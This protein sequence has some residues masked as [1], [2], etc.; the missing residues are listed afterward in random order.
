ML[1]PLKGGLNKPKINDLVLD[2]NPLVNKD[3]ELG[4]KTMEIDGNIETNAMSTRSKTKT[5]G[6][7][8]IMKKETPS[9]RKEKENKVSEGLKRTHQKK[10]LNES[11]PNNETQSPAE[12]SNELYNDTE[13]EMDIDYEPDDNESEEIPYLP[14]STFKSEIQDLKKEDPIIEDF[15]L[16][17]YLEPEL[18]SITQKL[19]HA[20]PVIESLSKPTIDENTTKGLA[21]KEVEKNLVKSTTI[22]ENM[23]PT[24]AIT[25]APK[26]VIRRKRVSPFHLNAI[27]KEQLFKGILENTELKFPFATGLGLIPELRAYVHNA[28]R[29][30]LIPVNE[31][32]D[33]E[34]VLN[35]I[36]QIMPNEIDGGDD[37][38]DE[39][40]LVEALATEVETIDD[41]VSKPVII[42]DALILGKKVKIKYDS[43]S[44][45]SFVS[46]A[47]VDQLNLQIQN[48]SAVVG[49]INPGSKVVKGLVE[50]TITIKGIELP[51]TMLIHENLP[52]DTI[53]VGRNFQ[54]ENCF[55][56]G[57]VDSD[58]NQELV[59]KHNNRLLKFKLLNEN[60]LSWKLEEDPLRIEKV[61]EELEKVFDNSILTNYQRSYFKNAI[62]GI[63]EVF[64]MPGDKPGK[65]DSNKFELPNIKLQENVTPWKAK[66]IP[67]GKYRND[68]IKILREM[69]DNG[70]LKYLNLNYRNPWFMVMKSNKSLRLLVDYRMLN[71]NILLQAA[72]PLNAM[73]M[74]NRMSGKY[75]CTF[76]DISNAYFQVGIAEDGQELTAIMTPIGLLQFAVLPQGYVNLV[77]NFT[78][79][80]SKILADVAEK[81]VNF[82]D[83]I[84]IIGP[85]LQEV[86]DND[87][88]MI[89]HLDNVVEV[90]SL[91]NKA[92]LK[93][94]IS[95]LKLAQGKCSFLGYTV[96]RLGATLLRKKA[97]AIATMTQPTTLAQLDRFVGMCNFYRR[98]IPAFS[99]ITKPLYQMI[100]LM[101]KTNVKKIPWNE[102][103]IKHFNY[104]KDQL[105]SSPV[106][107]PINYNK[108]ITLHCDANAST[109]AGVLQNL[110]D[111]GN[112]TLI[113]CA[114]GSFTGAAINYSIHEKELEAIFLS[115]QAFHNYFLNF[116][117]T[118]YIYSDNQALTKLIQSPFKDGHAIN[119]IAKW[120]NYLRTYNYK[121]V[122]VKGSENIIAD[123]LSRMNLPKSIEH[124][125]SPIQDD[126]DNFKTQ[127]QVNITHAKLIP[128]DANYGKY[129]LQDIFIYLTTQRVPMKYAEVPQERKKFIF[130]AMEFFIS[131]GNLYKIGNNGQ[132]ARKVIFNNNEVLEIFQKVHD[133]WGHMKV[134]NSFNYINMMFFIPNLYKKL[135]QYISSCDICQRYDG[136][137]TTKTP[138]YLNLPGNM[139]DT[140]VLDSVYIKDA[141]LVVGR[142]EFSNWVEAAILPELNAQL[143]ADFLFREFFARFGACTKIHTDN[144]IEFKN[145]VMKHLL[146]HYHVEQKFSIVNHP[147]GN[148][149]IERNHR[150]FINFFRKLPPDLD[151][152]KYLQVALMVDRNSICSTTGYS[153]HYMVYGFFGHSNLPSLYYP[154]A[155]NKVYTEDELFKFRINQ[156]RFRE[157]QYLSAQRRTIIQREI[158]KKNFDNRNK[159]DAGMEI[160][161]LVLLWD[162]MIKNEISNK[163]DK[164]AHRWAGPFRI[165]KTGTRIYFLED[166]D[167]TKIK[168]GFSRQQLKVYHD[169]KTLGF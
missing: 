24:R 31:V 164:L 166:L 159:L 106:I 160:G 139:F 161:D 73:E 80:L 119:R 8:L 165:W 89:Q 126:I 43:C 41:K 154:I 20:E 125:T 42:L 70:Q 36:D 26:V 44:N 118:L 120:L 110:D 88:A 77:S 112:Y 48:Y 100:V 95:K 169:R 74:V 27:Q 130:R 28:T 134:G 15:T 81:V 111:D 133:Q 132:F 66:T 55:S 56:V 76:I 93:I 85:S 157:T 140:I 136:L 163:M 158:A 82:V 147:E 67:L 123:C 9:S 5:N 59:F 22:N 14:K 151:W 131:D 12:V 144:G 29:S 50:T 150:R 153:A 51:I 37:E 135:Q 122:H 115:L 168:K 91:L 11:K 78:N 3:E 128:I 69:V 98:L 113:D 62:I 84:G 13:G 103:T 52:E 2:V 64:H 34:I 23:E 10:L 92:G 71:K 105:S 116:T 33:M 75:C 167:G 107:A 72:H 94:N 124:Y 21:T 18:E 117:D 60:N 19:Q 4:Q 53:L 58:A 145:A 152:K 57:Y 1:L 83:D 96:D 148:G 32:N 65:L 109:W 45:S 99:T 155:E 38:N 25:D 121:L 40:V 162:R 68:A 97:D 102:T 149:K 137:P 143:V 129:Q 90:L 114:A 35:D 54:H 39:S 7:N 104:L 108:K 63:S 16:E 47:L 146:D 156:L 61:W 101:R 127:L 49:G 46:K 30:K 87:D 141:W 79:I 17:N 86:K 138:L 142:C 6:N